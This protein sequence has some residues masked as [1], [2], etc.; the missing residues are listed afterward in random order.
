MKK[1]LLLVGMLAVSGLA[2]GN[3]VTA[4][5]NGQYEVEGDVIVKAKVVETLTMDGGNT[6]VDFGTLLRGQLNKPEVEAGQLTI[7]GAPNTNIVI[8]V[9][10]PDTEKY[11][12]MNEV[13]K[14]LGVDLK[15]NGNDATHKLS[16]TLNFKHN[17]A[18]INER[19]NALDEKGKFVI[20]IHG[21]ASANAQQAFGNYHE[22]VKVKAQ[23]E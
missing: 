8:T 7:S 19:V 1:M 20:D 6:F 23:Y 2:F 11:Q 14:G 9:K 22:T 5:G 18:V 16:T 13:V 4:N 15:L 3:Q 21:L 17:N 10:S 12:T